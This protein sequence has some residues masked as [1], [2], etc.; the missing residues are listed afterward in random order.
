MNIL[1]YYAHLHDGSLVLLNDGKL[2]TSI[3]AEKNSQD[4]YAKMSL[5]RFFQ[6]YR[7]MESSLSEGVVATN[8]RKFFEEEEDPYCGVL[9][10]KI[11][12]DGVCNLR[13]HS[14]QVFQTSH[15]RAHLM[16]S[17]AMSP[18]PQGQACY[19]LCW[20]GVIGGF[21][22]IDEKLQI[23]KYPDIML[24]PGSRYTLAHTIVTKQ[25]TRS[26][27]GKAMALAGF[28]LKESEIRPEWV[29]IIQNILS[30]ELDS[31]RLP[32]SAVDSDSVPL[33]KLDR[34]V[35]ELQATALTKIGVEHQDFK[36]FMYAL[37]QEIFIRFYDYANK[38]FTRGLPLIISGGCGL[39]CDWNT[40]WKDCGLFSDVFIPPVANDSGQ[41]IG[42]AVDAQFAL[43]GNAKIDWS[44]YAGEEFKIDTDES[45]VYSIQPLDLNILTD[46]LVHGEAVAWVQGKY[47][48]GPRALC[49]RSLLAAPFDK[50]MHTKLNTIKKREMYRPIAPVV[51]EEDVNT[52]F[53]WTGPSPY[54]LHFMRVKDPRLQAVTHVDGTAR[55][56]T[57]TRQQDALT[58]DL[59][60]AFER[61]TGAPVLCNTSLNWP[62]KGFI[63]ELHDLCN[64][65]Q[66]TGIR[67][68]VVNDKLYIQK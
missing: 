40:R 27:A 11:W 35:Q 28:G 38:N 65:A 18:F 39:N 30:S 68:L 6:F 10:E 29:T 4:R 64:Y 62:G 49:H 44:P 66:S 8:Y 57:L 60:K 23:T 67:I 22:Y 50:S 43:T 52:Y 14:Q 41:G 13:D 36:N 55:A 54:M 24:A 17:Y 34:C 33:S 37:T 15:E 45:S 31:I 16:S 3:E 19:A 1:G 7:E 9:P 47:E 42:R 5:E 21:Y 2:V 25:K 63:N 53:D 20:E 56:Q 32:R 58:Y 26:A 59:L 46:Y 12:T 48:I 61:K 51:T